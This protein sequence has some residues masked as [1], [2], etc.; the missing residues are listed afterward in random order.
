MAEETGIFQSNICVL[1]IG[2]SATEVVLRFELNISTDDSCDGQSCSSHLD[3]ILFSIDSRF[4]TE[5][6]SIDL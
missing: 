1:E 2:I 4:F 6:S 3:A 5:E